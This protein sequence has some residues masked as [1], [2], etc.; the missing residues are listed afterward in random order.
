MTLHVVI[1]RDHSTDAGTFGVLTL[2]SGW[3][4][5]TLELPWRNNVRRMS[6]I[7]AGVYRAIDHVSPRFGRTYW[8]QDV[9]G[10]SEILIHAGNLAGDT[11]KGYRSDVAGCILVGATRGHLQ[12]QPAV[13]SSKLA[14][15]ALLKNLAGNPAIM[16][17]VRDA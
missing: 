8:L 7:P 3:R 10:R 9:P 5:Q 16:L 15:N 14:L 13:L 17:D 2:P 11:T 12:G 4:C 6:C 1:Q